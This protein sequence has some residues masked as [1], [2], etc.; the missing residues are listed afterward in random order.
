MA[1]VGS[2]PD[3]QHLPRRKASSEL[4]ARIVSAAILGLIALLVTWLGGWL[5]ALFWLAAGLAILVEW[6]GMTRVEPV[7]A[8]Q[9]LLGA[10]LIA[11]VIV[12]VLQLPLWVA[13]LVIAGAAVASHM[14]GVSPRD[15]WWALGGFAYAAVIALAPTMVRD[16]PQ[17]GVVGV[18]W[19]FA[20][21]WTSDIVAYFTGRRFGGPKLWPRVSPKK[22]WSG[23]LGGLTGGALV[24]TLVVFLGQ[25]WGGP[26]IVSLWLVLLVSAAASVVGQLGDLA[27]SALKRAFEVKDSGW[28][29]PGHGGVM[30]RLD[31]FWPVALMAALMLTLAA[32][33]A[34]G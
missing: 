31:A 13:A 32:Q 17:A 30:D 19:M 7:Q 10:G 20:V 29:I 4:N 16:H 18:L 27:E 3:H 12:H 1:G 34:R 33:P 2:S 6:M 28:L 9:G 21:V 5:F 24:G 15:R 14:M 26:P 25:R 23:F 11:L 8:L 22:T